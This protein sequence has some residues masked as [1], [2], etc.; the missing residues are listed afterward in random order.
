MSLG[1][2]NTQEEHIKS[3]VNDEIESTNLTRAA[4]DGMEMLLKTEKWFS[5]SKQD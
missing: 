4:D 3:T 1:N 2:F 5:P